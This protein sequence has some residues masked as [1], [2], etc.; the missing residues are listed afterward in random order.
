MF[1][2]TKFFFLQVLQNNTI[3]KF[4]FTY[5]ISC[6]AKKQNSRSHNATEKLAKNN[7]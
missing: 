1:S 2:D 5:L 7:F 3:Y 6:P 4:K